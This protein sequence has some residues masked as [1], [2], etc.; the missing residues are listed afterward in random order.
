M[1][2]EQMPHK[3]TL[4]ERQQLTVTGVAEVVSFEDTAVVL[5]TG[6]GTLVVQ[7]RDLQLKELSVTGGEVQVVGTVSSL[8]YEEPRESGGWLRRWLG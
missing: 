3:L 6:L 4:N 7:G 1:E 8:L 2:R 5:R